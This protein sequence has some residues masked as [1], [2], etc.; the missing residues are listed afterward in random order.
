MKTTGV[1]ESIK[2][3]HEEK[4]VGQTTEAHENLWNMQLSGVKRGKQ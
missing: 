1:N 2:G 3:Y 4:R